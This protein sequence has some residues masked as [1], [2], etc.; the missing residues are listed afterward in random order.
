MKRNPDQALLSRPL[1][2]EEIKD[3]TSGEMTATEAERSAIARMLDLVALER[4]AFTYRITQGGEGRLHLTGRLAAEVTQ[5]CVVSLD[6]VGASLDVPVEVDFWPAFL[7]DALERSSEEP[8][9]SGLL[10]WPEAIVE[11]KIDLGPL[12]YE[13]LATALDP[14]PKREGASFHWPQNA[15][16]TPESAPTGPFAALAAL[17]RR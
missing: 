2:V 13:T 7:L 6:P 10:D 5:T 12:I 14:Y 4:L 8:G 17:K 1:K 3:G 15:P 11:G 9:H 16:K